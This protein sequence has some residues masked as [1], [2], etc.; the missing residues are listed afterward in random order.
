MAYRNLVA[1]ACASAGEVWRHTKDFLT[2][3]N[4]IANYSSSGLGWSLVD[5]SFAVDA[6]TP[7][8]GDWVVLSSP[9]EDGRE[10]LYYRILYSSVANSI[11]RTRAGLSWDAAAH[12]WVTP[13]P[14]AEQ[15]AGPTAGTSFTVAVYGDLDGFT[16]LVGDGTTWY[17]RHFGRT[18]DTLGDP[19]V[20][21][22]TGAVSAGSS[23]V[24]P[25]DTVP[26]SW[27]VGRAVIIRDEA[28][29]ERAVISALGAGA[30]TLATLANGYAAGARL[31][32]DHVVIITNST[33]NLDNFNALVGR[34]GAVVPGNLVAARV[35]S[36]VL[37]DADPDQLNGDHATEFVRLGLSSGTNIIGLYGRLRNILQVSTVGITAGVVYADEAGGSWR[38]YTLGASRFL[39]KEE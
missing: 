4:G 17:A 2:S 23:I 3:R 19:T 31:S 16:I 7:T 34:G 35:L 37:T 18:A 11:L 20:A 28:K 26:S 39:F 21:L 15:S 25:V 32:G 24:V 29:I 38:A 22:A 8:V 1:C 36:T 27:A 9:G 33:Y 13:F 5:S 10:A 6:D 14:S 12:N 30:V